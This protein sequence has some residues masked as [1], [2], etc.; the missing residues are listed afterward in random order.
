MLSFFNKLVL[1]HCEIE[2]TAFSD[3]QMAQQ[4]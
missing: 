3:D 4:T 2:N 1:I